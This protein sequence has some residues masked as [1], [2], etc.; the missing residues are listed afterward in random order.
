MMRWAV[1]L[2]LTGLL[3]PVARAQ[4]A[5]TNARIA[6]AAQAATTA[7]AGLDTWLG[8]DAV[9]PMDVPLAA[10]NHIIDLKQ[11]L[12]N[13]LD[14]RF[15]CEAI[16]QPD[17]VAMRK[18]LLDRIGPAFRRSTG[19]GI[20]QSGVALRLFRLPNA[21]DWLLADAS[22][23]INTGDDHLLLAYAFRDGQWQRILRWQSGR[24]AQISGA[25]GDFFE[26]AAI[27]QS[28]GHGPQLV[29]AHGTPW[30]TSRWSAFGLDVIA[31]GHDADAADVLLH[32]GEDY[33]RGSDTAPSLTATQDGFELRV[34]AETLGGV[35]D[36]TAHV[37][38]YR[39]ADGRFQRVQPVADGV[40]GFADAVLEAPMDEAR[41]WVAP[42]ALDAL[43]RLRAELEANKKALQY[44]YRYDS[45]MAC[46]G[47]PNVTELPFDLEPVGTGSSTSAVTR[48]NYLRLR[49][50]GADRFTLLSVAPAPDP[51]CR[52]GS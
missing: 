46:A 45:P 9:N 4:P 38:R 52:P 34:E 27:P 26:V 17:L 39:E 29:V 18:A 40:V 33:D 37:F 16:P 23:D 47:E 8:Q 6:S 1:G 7:R 3:L 14:A 21:P 43:A 31:P 13:L 2:L 35:A 19:P 36:T 24:Y 49:S 41:A 44:M 51:R 5:C 28:P 48:H 25:F 15:A 32:R 30:P 20:E 12:T 22:F 42:A 11:A 50:D 10:Q